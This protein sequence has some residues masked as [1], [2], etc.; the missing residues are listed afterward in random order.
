M[1]FKLLILTFVFI[2]AIFATACSSNEEI[3]VNSSGNQIN[4]TSDTDVE[5]SEFVQSLEELPFDEI[6]MDG[7]LNKCGDSIC[8][9]DQCINANCICE[10][11]IENCA[12]DCE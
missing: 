10:E 2:L 5:T 8:N 4:Q 12:I 3:L 1:D 6:T 7:C 11:T 9:D